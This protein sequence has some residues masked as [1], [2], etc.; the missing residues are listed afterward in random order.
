MW[1]IVTKSNM[2]LKANSLCNSWRNVP[3]R[4]HGIWWQSL[5]CCSLAREWTNSRSQKLQ[6]RDSTS[7]LCWVKASWVWKERWQP[8][9][10]EFINSMFILL[11]QVACTSQGDTVTHQVVPKLF[12]QGLCNSHTGPELRVWEQSDVSPCTAVCT[13]RNAKAQMKVTWIS[14]M[15]ILSCVSLKGEVH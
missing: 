10:C 5:K 12:I 1:L 2:S 9:F 8:W 13:I 4:W 3:W 11:N 7:F 14:P 15:V 6:V